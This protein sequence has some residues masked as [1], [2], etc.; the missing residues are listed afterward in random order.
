MILDRSTPPSYSIPEDF[1]L[2][3]PA[4]KILQN[5]A[6]HFHFDTPGIQ[7]VKI[8]LIGKGTRAFLPLNEALVPSFTLQMLTEGTASKSSSEIAHLLDFHASEIQPYLTFGQEGITLIST[9]KHLFQVLELLLEVITQPSFPEEP[10]EK[11]KA[12]RRLMIEMERKKT[13]SQA[14]QLFRKTLFGGEHPYGN[15]IHEEMLEAINSERL[16]QHSQQLLWQGLEI[17]T[18]GDFSEEERLALEGFL[19]RLP[20]QIPQEGI[21]LPDPNSE[22][23]IYESRQDAVQSSI[24]MGKLSIPKN[25]PDFIPLSVFNTIL[26]GYFGSRLI[27]N[28]REDKGHTYGIYS[29]LVQMG[30]LNYW[31]VGADVEKQYLELVKTEIKHE[32][33]KLS[34]DLVEEDELETVRN[35]LLGQMLSQFSNSFDLIDRFRSVHHSGLDLNY[36]SQKLQFLKEFKA[37]DILQIGQKYFKDQPLIEASVG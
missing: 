1:S 3:S 31:A 18:A 25:H 19:E 12:Q 11:R 36:Y 5:G 6:A 27:K 21:L 16:Q 34:T 10:L 28:I 29:S 9:K 20:N 7:A 33:E 35:Y 2:Q 23:S 24:R 13:A 14:S 32:I 4:E 17:F 22:E 37:E 26:G 15:M 8:D 30:N